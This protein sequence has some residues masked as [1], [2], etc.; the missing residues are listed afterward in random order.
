MA[1]KMRKELPVKEWKI[2]VVEKEM[3]HYYQPGFLFIP[4]GYY[5]RRRYFKACQEILSQGVEFVNSEI[6]KIDAAEN[7]VTLKNGIQ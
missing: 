5:K 6:E 3:N 1:N 2:T 7:N 4:F